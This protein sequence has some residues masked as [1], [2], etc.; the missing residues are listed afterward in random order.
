MKQHKIYI[1]LT[2]V[3]LLGCAAVLNFLPRSTVSALEKRDLRSFPAF[4]WQSLFDG[5]F[6]NDI[7]IGAVM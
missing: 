7:S 4:S 2:A 6:A 1:T 3:F 5:S